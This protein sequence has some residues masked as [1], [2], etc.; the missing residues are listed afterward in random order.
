M[1]RQEYELS[2]DDFAALMDAS[3][4][5]PAMWL[6]DGTPM[7][8]TPQENANR[9]W[10]QLGGRLGFKPMTVRPIDGKDQKFFSAEP[11]A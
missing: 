3:K 11:V 2:D 10:S 9:A 6:S 8:G 7:S 1:A 4:P 5:T